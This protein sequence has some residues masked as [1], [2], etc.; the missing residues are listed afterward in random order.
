MPDH[1]RDLQQAFDG[2]APQFER[3]PVTADPAA[4]ERLVAFAALPPASRVL[5]AGCGPGLVSEALLRAGHRVIGVDLSGEMVARARERCARFGERARFERQSVHDPLEGD[6]DAAVSRFVVHHVVDPLAFVRR[7][8]ELLRPGGVLLVSDH[9]TDPDPARARWHAEVERL[10]DGTHVRNLTPGEIAD[11][12]AAAGL[13]SLR[14]AEEPFALDFDEWFD[15]GTPSGSKEEV[16][17]LLLAGPGAR[18]F[19]PVPSGS[20]PIR[21]DCW[22]LLARGV[23]PRA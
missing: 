6:L 21:I 11:A 10:R 7:Q 17:A 15:R 13:E 3:S 1:D 5:D 2:Q 14:L 18:G 22:R 8:V 9:T 4:L 19:A 23:R 20:G 12:F 16:R